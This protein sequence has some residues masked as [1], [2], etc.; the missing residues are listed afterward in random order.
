MRSK[1][2]FRYRKL[3][4]ERT[5]RESVYL[6]YK[7]ILHTFFEEDRI[8]IVNLLVKASKLL[9]IF[10]LL[11]LTILYLLAE[12]VYSPQFIKG[13]FFGGLLSSIYTI[14]S[15][16][17]KFSQRSLESLKDEFRF[18]LRF[19][20]KGKE[21]PFILKK[22]SFDLFRG[23]LV[24]SIVPYL[25]SLITASLLLNQPLW[26][27]LFGFILIFFN[28]ILGLSLLIGKILN[29]KVFLRTIIGVVIL[30]FAKSLTL[31]DFERALQIKLG[32]LSSLLPANGSVPLSSEFYLLLLIVSLSF[33]I[34][35]YI[36]S[37]LKT[38]FVSSIFL[39]KEKEI[40]TFNNNKSIYQR[41]LLRGFYARDK[42]LK[43]RLA[44]IM[45]VLLIIL[46]HSLLTQNGPIVL[47][48]TI[49]IIG[50]SP[51][52]FNLAFNGYL[53]NEILEKRFLIS[54][55]YIL[56]KFNCQKYFLKQTVLVTLSQSTV[57]LCPFIVFLILFK[58]MNVIAT[59]IL[60]FLIFLSIILLSATRMYDL[61]KFQFEQIR[62]LTPFTLT[63]NS[64]ENYI[65]YGIPLVYSM[66]LG[67]L[68]L[69]QPYLLYVYICM[70][71][72][73]ATLLFY[74]L[75]KVYFL[76]KGA[77]NAEYL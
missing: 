64:A 67:I 72:Y 41:L 39:E 2:Y 55:Y 27:L 47:A 59:V 68:Q 60:Y 32:D 14:L 5:S 57:L 28:Y 24:Y 7:K 11:T 33:L 35:L 1:S 16:H 76:I 25:F 38:A 4:H 3:I 18:I 77:K 50:Y 13:L 75:L 51:S 65:I 70:V 10:P 71:G 26:V 46:S 17:F 19:L 21:S 31:F 44:S 52:V 34:S 54:T 20:P 74:C 15:I 23:P 29:N 37:S 6:F 42:I 22:I 12:T 49:L 61:K 30:L 48:L 62:A 53:Y 66:P 56:K 9:I 58:A 69:S 8:K 43:L 73:T 36:L 40:P 45:L 63:S